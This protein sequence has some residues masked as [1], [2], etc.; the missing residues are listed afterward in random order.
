MFCGRLLKLKVL[1]DPDGMEPTT[2]ASNRRPAFDCFSM[3]LFNQIHLQPERMSTEVRQWAGG[4]PGVLHPASIRCR[5]A[6]LLPL[7]LT[8]Y[9]A[10]PPGRSKVTRLFSPTRVMPLLK[11]GQPRPATPLPPRGE[12]MEVQV[13]ACLCNWPR[14]TASGSCPL[15]GQPAWQLSTPENAARRRIR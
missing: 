12:S 8:H 14:P 2:T 1:A 9:R 7:A 4:S 10:I 3:L 11:R 6:W 13:P 15:I 5:S